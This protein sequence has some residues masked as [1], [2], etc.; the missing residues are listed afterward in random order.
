MLY[1][2]IDTIPMYIFDKIINTGELGLLGKH[3][4]LDSAWCFIFD[5]YT[6]ANGGLSD[7]YKDIARLKLEIVEHY[8][9]AYVNNARH[10]LTL[11]EIKEIEIA[12][13]SEDGVDSD[14]FRTIAQISKLI[15]FRLDPMT[16]TAREFINYK[17][18]AADVK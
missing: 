5:E 7:Q 9:N 18:L 6:E 13:I 11:A 8:Y 17:K 14:Y 15:G 10:D 1:N 12:D 3:K 16:I 2:N 4:D